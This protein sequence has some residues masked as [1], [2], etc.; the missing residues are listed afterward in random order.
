MEDDLDANYELATDID[1]LNTAQ[2][3]NGNGFDPVGDLSNK[4]TGSL[5]GNNHTVTGLTI[6]RST[7]DYVGLFG[8]TGISSTLTYIQITNITVN[9]SVNVGGLVGYNRGTIQ[10]TTISGDINGSS[11]VGGLVAHNNEGKIRSATASGNISGSDNVGGLVAYNGD[12]VI[13]D[14][15]ASGNVS[16]LKYIGG[17]SGYNGDSEGTIRDTTASVNVSGSGYVGGFVGLSDGTIRDATASGSVTGLHPQSSVGRFALESHSNVGGLVGDNRGTILNATA[18]GSVTGLDSTGLDLQSN[19]GGLVG[20]NSVGYHGDGA[21]RNSTASGNVTGDNNVGGLIG[22]N[23]DS[24]IQ[25]SAASGDINVTITDFHSQS[26]VGGLVGNNRG[27]IRNTISSSDIIISNTIVGGPI[28]SVGGLVGANK[29]TI[30]D[31][32][33]VGSMTLRG[34]TFTW[35]ESGGVVGFNAQDQGTVEDSYWDRDATGQSTSAG[36][37]TDLTT[38]EMQGPTAG[39]NMSGLDFVNTWQVTDGYPE[40]RVLS[41]RD[42]GEDPPE[43]GSPSINPTLKLNRDEV[44]RG[45]NLNYTIE[46]SSAG[47]FH[48]VTVNPSHFKDTT[49]IPEAIETM[50]NVGA[51]TDRGV[52]DDDGGIHRDDSG[53]N[54]VDIGYGFA[55][56][57][58]GSGD[59]TGSINTEYLET[60]TVTLEL[61]ETSTTDSSNNVY[62]DGELTGPNPLRGLSATSTD[63]VLVNRNSSGGT[64]TPTERVQQLTGKDNPSDLTQDDVTITITRF[65]RGQSING[66]TIRQNDIT[67][68]ITL[69]ERN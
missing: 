26:N 65:Q 23:N 57:E 38:A 22:Y 13:K 10:N 4:F 64:Q 19:V 27:T 18:S 40:L 16:G 43:S 62:S 1:A 54:T 31:T 7:E 5:N 32:L 46:N 41:E 37:A 2:W 63:N 30:R 42:V 50:R 25:N 48:I 36:N 56:V 14:S 17:I 11:G 47:N 61:Y 15:A 68:L 34:D 67:S 51:V 52:I 29:G 58:I 8:G 21:I 69:F 20:Y 9:G 33:V 35:P 53:I 6:N 12:G 55:V 3:N 49:D 59:G 60:T 66:I 44:T 24:V 39:S 45:G 28:N